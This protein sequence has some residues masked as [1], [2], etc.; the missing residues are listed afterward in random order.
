MKIKTK[1]LT[2]CALFAALTAVCSQI[3]IPIPMVPINLAL[4]ATYLAGTI[5]GPLY[6]T[7]SIFAYVVLGAVGVPVFA[8]FNG[9]LGVVVGPTGGYIVGFILSAF[10]TG[11][12]TKKFGYKTSTLVIAMLAGMLTCYILGTI[13]FIHV[14][15]NNLATSLTYCVYPFLPGDAVKIAL[16]TL[17]TNRIRKAL[18]DL[19]V[20]NV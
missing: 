7:V 5:L 8:G 6:G 4:F 17:M 18:P 3:Q 15:N 14:T 11:L 20:A 12:I 2:M 1:T 9:G 13:W 19:V 10:I 16:A